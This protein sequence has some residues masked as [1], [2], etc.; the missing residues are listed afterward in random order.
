MKI[1]KIREN[2]IKIKNIQKLFL[3]NIESVKILLS[4]EDNTVIDL[5][6]QPY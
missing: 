6:K 2:K 4:A 1:N 3:I 5:I